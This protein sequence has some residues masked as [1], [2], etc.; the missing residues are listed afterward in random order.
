MT[1]YAAYRA[2]RQLE[3]LP[4]RVSAL[5]DRQARAEAQ[6]TAVLGSAEEI[7]IPGYRVMRTPDGIAVSPTGAQ[8]PDGWAQLKIEET[9]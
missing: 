1:P 2:A 5:H 8:L 3:T 4:A 7:S 6:L 9:R